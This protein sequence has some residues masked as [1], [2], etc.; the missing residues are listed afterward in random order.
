MKGLSNAIRETVRQRARGMCEYCL[1]QE[2]DFL[3]PHEAD[4]IVPVQHGGTTVVENL[5]LACIRCNRRKGPN[6]TSVD[7]DSSAIVLLY[8]PRQNRWADHFVLNG[9]HIAGF[10]PI[11]RATVALLQ[12]N[13]EE[14]LRTRRRLQGFGRLHNS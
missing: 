14:R 8:H 3:Y 11:G 4:H 13:S 6:L 12:L 1:V 2:E 9:I 10:T 5:A 7:P